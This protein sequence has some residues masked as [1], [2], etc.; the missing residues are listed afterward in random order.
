ML[1]L[2]PPAQVVPQVHSKDTNESNWSTFFIRTHFI[3]HIRYWISSE[4][5]K[6]YQIHQFQIWGILNTFC[7]SGV[8]FQSP[9][10]SNGV[11]FIIQVFDITF[12]SSPMGVLASHR[13]MLPVSLVLP[14]TW[15]ESW[16]PCMQWQN[17]PPFPLHY[18]ILGRK[19][20]VFWKVILWFWNLGYDLWW[21]GAMFKGDFAHT[22]A[23]K[24][25]A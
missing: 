13:C 21:V 5:F 4:Y 9:I 10:S 15:L 17:H 2:V 3:Y 14:L 16:R 18:A 11:L 1:S 24:F 6:E 7:R 22:C 12:S 20:G 23:D 25:P 19:R 8:K